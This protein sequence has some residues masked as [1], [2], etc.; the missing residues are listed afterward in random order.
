MAEIFRLILSIGSTLSS[1][2]LKSFEA[3]QAAPMVKAKFEQFHQDLKDHE[4]KID[5][6]AKKP[7][8][9]REEHEK[10]LEQMRLAAS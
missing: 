7:A 8:A 9:T 10:L 1:I 3:H 6:L 5:K 4:A 2:A